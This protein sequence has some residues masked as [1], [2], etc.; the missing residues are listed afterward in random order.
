MES[1]EEIEAEM[2]KIPARQIT[3]EDGVEMSVQA[4]AYHYSSPRKNNVRYTHVEVGF[5]SEEIPELSQYI[6][7][8]TEEPT[9]S[10]YPYVP[11]SVVLEIIKKHG[12][13][14]SG[15]LVPLLVKH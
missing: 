4:S 11:A 7:G 10:V 12:G 2:N 6:E 14:K 15:E 5:P 3:L 9:K 1:I 8:I 13:I